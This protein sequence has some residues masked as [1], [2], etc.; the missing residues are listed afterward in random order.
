LAYASDVEKRKVEKRG[1]EGLNFFSKKNSC[2]F[3]KIGQW[4]LPW[5]F[6]LERSLFTKVH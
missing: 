2:S 6:H 3:L 5:Y 4:F 1:E